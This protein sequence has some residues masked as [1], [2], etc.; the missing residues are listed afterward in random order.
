M[1]FSFL[2]W[3]HDLL[4]WNIHFRCSYR[5]I[6][7]RFRSKIDSTRSLQWLCPNRW[8]YW[9]IDIFYPSKKTIKKV[10]I[11]LFRNSLLFVNILAIAFGSLLL[12]NNQYTFL[13]CRLFQGICVG[14]YSA[15]TPLIIK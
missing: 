11:I 12:I 4:S 6:L 8:W 3:L 14:F 15:I 9:G 5:K 1:L 10:I 2:L 13:L 7:N